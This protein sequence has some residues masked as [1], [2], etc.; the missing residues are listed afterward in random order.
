MLAIALI[1]VNQIISDL[2][3]TVYGRICVLL[4]ICLVT[5]KLYKHSVSKLYI[6]GTGSLVVIGP[7]SKSRIDT[8]KIKMARVY[9]IPSSMTILLKVKKIDAKLPAFFYF[10]A[11]STNHGSYMDTKIKL[12]SLLEEFDSAE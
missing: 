2:N 5:L 7:F 3:L 6:T 1:L 11:V 12:L 9:G 4:I 10:I 8:S